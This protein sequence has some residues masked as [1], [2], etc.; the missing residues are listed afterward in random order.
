M[1]GSTGEKMLKQIDRALIGAAAEIDIRRKARK[2]GEDEDKAVEKWKKKVMGSNRERPRVYRKQHADDLVAARRVASAL[3][4]LRRETLSVFI[5]PKKYHE[6]V[7]GKVAEMLVRF[8]T[9]KE[10][11]VL[12]QVILGKWNNKIRRQQEHKF[13]CQGVRIGPERE[14]G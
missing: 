11:T 8:L 4:G 7:I 12:A 6:Q 10:S 2:W 3:M 9:K 5:D 13:K 1:M 14:E